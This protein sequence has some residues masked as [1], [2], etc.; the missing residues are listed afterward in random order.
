MPRAWIYEIGPCR[1]SPV[2][3]ETCTW[4]DARQY[5]KDELED[6]E[7]CQ[8]SHM[9]EAGTQCQV[10]DINIGRLL[11]G[12]VYRRTRSRILGR[13]GSDGGRVGRERAFLAMALGS[14]NPQTLY[15]HESSECHEK[16]SRLDECWCLLTRSTTSLLQSTSLSFSI[17]V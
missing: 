14:D 15:S 1:K 17:R 3:R 11:E 16:C 8:N 4:R 2:I 7:R 9:S 6:D 13:H 10:H 12:K 5:T